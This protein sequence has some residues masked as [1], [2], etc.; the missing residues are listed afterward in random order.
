MH[1]FW[2]PTDTGFSVGVWYP[3]V[4]SSIS[5]EK[6]DI[7]RMNLNGLTTCSG[8]K[9]YTTPEDLWLIVHFFEPTYR[10]A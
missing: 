9:L 6:R 1:R 4:S 2:G 5:F 10:T 7:L 3:L 8:F